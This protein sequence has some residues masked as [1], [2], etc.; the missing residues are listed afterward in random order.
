M[1]WYLASEGYSTMQDPSVDMQ[2]LELG[3]VLTNFDVLPFCGL[4][5][6][7]QVYPMGGDPS[8]ARL[9]GLELNYRRIICFVQ[10]EAWLMS[11]T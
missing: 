9:G 6:D 5:L 3:L 10:A 8:H 1:G 4:I 2:S 7:A 11:E